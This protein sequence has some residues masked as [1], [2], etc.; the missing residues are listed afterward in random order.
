MLVTLELRD[1]S[2]VLLYS[3]TEP[4][5]SP[6]KQFSQLLLLRMGGTAVSNIANIANLGKQ[7]TYSGGS[8][9][10]F[11]AKGPVNVD[12]RGIVIGTGA[13]A[14]TISDYALATQIAHGA[15]VGQMSHAAQTNPADV[16]TSD[17]DVTFAMSRVFTN[18]SGAAIVIRETGIYA[19]QQTS[20]PGDFSFCVIRDTPAALSVA[21]G[22]TATVTYTLRITE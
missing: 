13:A 16:T 6:L 10:A 4:S 7:G 15:G 21:N 19:L 3:K 9:V 1:C 5:R 18:N 12:T 14:V 2:G 17:P 20:D 11:Q 8:G 22:A